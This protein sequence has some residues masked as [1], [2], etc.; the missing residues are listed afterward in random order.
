M[1]SNDGRHRL[2]LRVLE[3][4]VESVAAVAGSTEPQR[5]VER[6]GVLHAI[7]NPAAGGGRAGRR[8]PSFSA[9]LEQR[10]Y[11]VEARFT[12]GAGDATSIARELA[13]GGAQTIVCVGGDGTLNE[14]ANGLI[15]DDGPVNSSTALALIPCGTGKDF[16]RTLGVRNLEL[17]LRALDYRYVAEVDVARVSCVN[18]R[19]GEQL[20]RCF[21]NVADG[22]LGAETAARINASSKALGGFVSYL[23]GAVRTIAAFRF[24]DATI[25]V[26]GVEFFSGRAGMV[27]FANGR[28]FAGGMVIAPAASVC[29]GQLDVFVLEDVGK[30]ALL[31]SLLPRVYRGRHVGQPGVLHRLGS[32]ATV[33]SSAQL[34]LELD[35]EQVG[36]APL[37]VEVLPRALRVIGLAEALSHVGGCASAAQ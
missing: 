4:N 24:R 15:A 35:G 12:R 21:V 32:A 16:A 17:A 27:V 11:L 37:R 3:L 34:L 31:S 10:G 33:R 8:W 6:S 20:A 26:D 23:S 13:L 25:E 5:G 7:I 2:A 29:D 22:G 14:I 30:R 28:Y 19:T 9:A 1:A 18:S 36:Q